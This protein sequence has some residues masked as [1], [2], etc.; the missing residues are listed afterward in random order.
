[1]TKV[2]KQ[3]SKT[4]KDSKYK[5][6]EQVTINRFIK[7]LIG[8]IVFIVLIYFAT[9]IFVKHDLLDNKEEAAVTEVSYSKMVFGTMLNR[10]YDEYYVYAYSS[11]DV[12]A[13]Y[14]NTLAANYINND[15]SLYV[16]YVDLEDSMNKKYISE[17]DETNPEAKSV[18]DLRVGKLTLMKVKNGKIVKYIEKL[19]DIKSEFG[20]N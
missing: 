12:K 16:Y 14:Y 11:E 7:I 10:P 13:Y 2:K 6:E 4:I 17:S 5:S 19:E 15:D 1:M 9:R 3:K 18:D 8:V 20:I